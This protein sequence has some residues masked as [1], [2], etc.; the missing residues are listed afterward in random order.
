MKPYKTKLRVRIDP[1]K[2]WLVMDQETIEK[3]ARMLKE[4]AELMVRA[5][6]TPCVDCGKSGVIVH[7]NVILKI[8][9]SCAM[10]RLNRL[11]EEDGD[12]P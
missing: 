11:F 7:G 5:A 1:H 6:M 4:K 8:C 2:H 10:K 9:A 12:D 3:V